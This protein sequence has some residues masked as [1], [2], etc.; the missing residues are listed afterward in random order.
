MRM[1]AAFPHSSLLADPLQSLV[2]VPS[3]ASLTGKNCREF[4]E[5][6]LALPPPL[7]TASCPRCETEG[8]AFRHLYLPAHQ[9]TGPYY[10]GNLPFSLSVG[11]GPRLPWLCVT[12]LS[13]PTSFLSCL[14][15]Q[16]SNPIS[17]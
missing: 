14:L 1:E 2:G 15:L 12:L 17:L 11:L 6:L 10:L 7:L 16:D 13:S 9:R 8:S 5:S 4:Q 3:A